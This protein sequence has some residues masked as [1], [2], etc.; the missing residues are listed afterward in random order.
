[1]GTEVFPT[2]LLFAKFVVGTIGVVALLTVLTAFIQ[3]RLHPHKKEKQE[4]FREHMI[5]GLI[6]FTI[7]LIVYF[8]LSAIGPAF[9]LLFTP[10]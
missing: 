2:L 3:Y 10:V 4:E 9:R 5:N 8:I 6:A 1:M 7:I